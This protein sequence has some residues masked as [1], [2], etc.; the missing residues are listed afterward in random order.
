VRVN[1]GGG[2]VTHSLGYY[3]ISEELL[4]NNKI[5]KNNIA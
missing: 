1:F 4:K 5:I 2:G 3:L